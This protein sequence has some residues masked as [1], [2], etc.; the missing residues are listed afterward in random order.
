[1]QIQVKTHCTA[2]WTTMLNIT[3]QQC[4]KRTKCVVQYV[5]QHVV[6]QFATL[7]KITTMCYSGLQIRGGKVISREVTEQRTNH[8]VA[9]AARPKKSI[10]VIITAKDMVGGSQISDCCQ[11]QN[12]HKTIFTAHSLAKIQYT[13]CLTIIKHLLNTCLAKS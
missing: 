5:V 1:M 3:T 8:M 12:I 10:I 7:C 9:K 2:L 4:I 13:I 6:Q 11:H